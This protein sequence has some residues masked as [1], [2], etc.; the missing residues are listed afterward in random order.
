MEALTETGS[1]T[2][3]KNSDYLD[4]LDVPHF[5]DCGDVRDDDDGHDDDDAHG[6]DRDDGHDGDRDDDRGGDRD[7]GRGDVHG[8]GG[9]RGGVH[10]GGDDELLLQAKGFQ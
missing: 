8:D 6:D 5:L 4:L 10:D 3:I 7:D 9:V 2:E 1:A